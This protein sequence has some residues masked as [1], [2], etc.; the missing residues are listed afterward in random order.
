MTTKLQ[1]LPYYALLT[2]LVAV[3]AVIGA[4]TERAGAA[5]RPQRPAA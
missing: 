2:V 3:F 1:L 5:P 4:A